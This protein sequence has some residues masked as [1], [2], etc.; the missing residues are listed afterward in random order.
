MDGQ[1]DALAV[2]RLQSVE[3]SPVG[4]I[5]ARSVRRRD[6]H[7]GARCHP[8][9]VRG[10]EPAGGDGRAGERDRRLGPPGSIEAAFRPA[11]REL[12]H[13]GRRSPRRPDF[14][15]ARGSPCPPGQRG[16]R[17]GPGRRIRGKPSTS[18]PR[19][20]RHGTSG[21]PSSSPAGRG[22]PARRGDG[23]RGQRRSSPGKASTV[24]TSVIQSRIGVSPGDA[25]ASAAPSAAAAAPPPPGPGVPTVTAVRPAEPIKG[26]NAVVLTA[27]VAG[28]VERL[29]WGLGGE[30]TS[31]AATI[32]GRLQRSVRFRPGPGCSRSGYRRSAPGARVRCSPAPSSMPRPRASAAG[33]SDLAAACATRSSAR[34]R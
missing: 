20:A 25:A 2:W 15:R 11:G 6:R 33:T 19:T 30:G 31:R 7:L 12:R 5:E 26:D 18:W 4:A 24:R 29:E 16:R 17:L 10:Q 21:R 1:G 32:N 13:R 23:R 9:R 28:P 3:H 8:R 14:D 34:R 22:R 27:D